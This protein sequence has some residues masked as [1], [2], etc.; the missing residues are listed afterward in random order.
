M[1]EAKRRKFLRDAIRF[2]EDTG[3]AA[4]MHL[5]RHD[6]LAKFLLDSLAGLTDKYTEDMFRWLA[7]GVGRYAKQIERDYV[8]CLTCDHKFTADTPWPGAF[9]MVS[10]YQAEPMTTGLM[11]CPVCWDCC[12]L[13][14][15][16]MRARGMAAFRKLWPDLKTLPIPTA[17]GTA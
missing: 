11:V 7:W 15:D 9:W 8:L 17:S 12:D 10:P 5:V 4:A 13:P 3:G 16:E 2:T 1:G 6:V 14:E